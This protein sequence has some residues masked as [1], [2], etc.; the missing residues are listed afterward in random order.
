[1][2][3]SGKEKLREFLKETL[4]KHGDRNDLTDRE[5]IFVSGRLDSF[6]MM[7]LVMH[8]EESFAIDFSSVEFDVGL[9]DSVNEI[10]SFVDSR[11]VK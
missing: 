11:S 1:M 3:I 10:E 8:L 9:L 2:N 7:M 4:A 6:S 5:S